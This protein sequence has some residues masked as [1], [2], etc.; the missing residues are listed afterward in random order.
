MDDLTQRLEYLVD[1]LKTAYDSV[2]HSS[3]RPYIYLVYPPQEERALRRLADE[4]LRDTESHRFHH[5]DI[6]EV[7][8]D[9]L[10]GKEEQREELLANPTAEANATQSILRL[11]ARR[12]AGLVKERLSLPGP[13]RPVVVLRGLAALHPLGNPTTLMESIA[14]GEP[15]DPVTNRVVPLVLLVPGLR[16][17]GASRTYDFLGRE[18]LRLQFYRGEEV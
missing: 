4:L 14:E 5:I 12:I 8:V 16:P 9:S 2:G 18:D 3:G 10:R 15:H 17:P 7:A 13:G 6:L 11:W 1:R